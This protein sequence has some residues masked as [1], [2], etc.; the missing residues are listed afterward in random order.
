M[1]IL[2]KGGIYGISWSV[3]D[4]SSNSNS[5]IIYS[6]EKRY[7]CQLRKE[8]R[9]ELASEYILMTENDKTRATFRFYSC[10]IIPGESNAFMMWLPTD[11]AHVEKILFR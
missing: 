1:T 10:C 3:V 4:T 8:Q 9:R 5:N 6:V 2:S 11:R 7:S